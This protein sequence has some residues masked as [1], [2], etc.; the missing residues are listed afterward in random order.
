MELICFALHY[1]KRDC[2]QHH[3]KSAG[4]ENL[5]FFLLS[6]PSLPS[7]STAA[8]KLCVKTSVNQCA[9]DEQ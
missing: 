1:V 2:V 9:E 5:V 8:A 6:Y 7:T 4:T 3:Y